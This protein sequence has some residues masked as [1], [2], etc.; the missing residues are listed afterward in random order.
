MANSGAAAGTAALDYSQRVVSTEP[1]GVQ[2]AERV[3]AQVVGHATHPMKI[4]MA[5]G[6]IRENME[7]AF[8]CDMSQLHTVPDVRYESAAQPPTPYPT[9]QA[10]PW[11]GIMSVQHAAYGLRGKGD[12]LTDPLAKFEADFKRPV[13]QPPP[14]S[15]ARDVG[16][17]DAAPETW[18]R[19]FW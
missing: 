3:V 15:G 18:I 2:V 10:T 5:M 19:A 11:G 13:V 7:H 16:S 1:P 17:P 12:L 9:P 8:T 4:A 6:Q 14:W